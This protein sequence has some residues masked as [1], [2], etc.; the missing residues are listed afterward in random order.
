MND[1]L[2]TLLADGIIDAVIGQLKTGK[3][4][5]VWLVQHAGQ[6]VAAKLYKERHERN[7][8][9]NSGYKE[10]R[11]VRNSRTRRAMEKGSRFGQAAAE[12][13]WKNAE[14]DSLYKLHAQGVR[15][16]TPV[17]FYEGILLMELVRDAEGQPA[18]RL[19]EAPPQTP[20]EAEALYMDLRAQVI[21]TLCAD[22]IHGDLSPYNILM[23]GSGATIIDFPQTVAAARNSQAEFYFRR[24]LDNVRQFL[25]GISPRLDGRA[26]DT[27]EIWNA[28]VRR[29]LTPEFVPSGA[30]REPPRKQA[31]AGRQ[32]ARQER[33]PLEEPRRNEFRPAPAP[34]AVEVE[35]GLSA[36]EAELR[37]LEALVLRQGGGERGRPVVTSSPRDGRRRGGGF[38]GKP[39]PRTG[40]APRPGNAGPQQN[41]GARPAQGGGNNN[42]PNGNPGR[43]QQGAP[44]N[45]APAQA[46]ANPPAAQADARTNGR[47]Q[48]GGPRNGNPRNEPRR[49]GRP[50]RSPNGEPRMN[51]QP[52]GENAQP[53]GENSQQRQN[54]QPQ[55][56]NGQQRRNGPPPGG[57]QGLNEQPRMNGQQ[58]GENG[59]APQRQ[60]GPRMNGQSRGGEQ[61]LN[62]QPRQNGQSRDGEQG[63]N[64]QPRQNGQPRGGEQGLN[65]QPRQGS[66]PRGGEQG[67][68]GQPRQGGQPRGGEQDLNGQPA[69]GESGP[70]AQ[71]P[72]QNGRA[73]R[74]EW[75]ANGRPQQNDGPRQ[76]DSRMNGQLRRNGGDRAEEAPARHGHDEAGMNGTPAQPPEESR[77]NGQP[78]NGG[79]R[80]NGRPPRNNGSF[81]DG[82][83]PQDG[84][85]RQNGRG[86]GPREA[87]GNLPNNGPRMPR[88][89][90]ERGSGRPSRGS[91][92]QVS[93]VGRPPA[94]SSSN[95]ETGS[96]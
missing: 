82:A 31:G 61:G 76:D 94:A 43:P 49:D 54:G 92:P 33:F 96:S 74:T 1:S 65:G 39:P 42:R 88:Q 57:E 81:Q 64:R 90:P 44:R 3:E 55:R 8:R 58:H 87:R 29:D 53:H 45:A 89:G 46:A 91:A 9:N 26:G 71:S 11:E 7:F 73:P 14:A 37:A 86:P 36:E 68:N 48:Q 67:L 38:G 35:E 4:A 41:A 79:P 56:Q 60:N 62:G 18:P 12:E 27:G 5:E 22:L 23:S 21:R 13:A 63:L 19:V 95:P 20:E 52:N 59:Q 51:G 17:L 24:D 66:Q 28:Y 93:Y 50:P 75:R 10:G 85:P 25:A 78:R 70:D 83:P 80:M 69:G 16:P 47:P 2:E 77:A 6:I 72:R 40:N 84:E 30:F 32:G 34:V 15:V